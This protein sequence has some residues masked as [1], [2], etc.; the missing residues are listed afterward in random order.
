MRKFYLL[1]Y[2]PPKTRRF[3]LHT[4]IEIKRLCFVSV[5]G[6]HLPEFRSAFFSANADAV[7][8]RTSIEA[9][10][11]T[12]TVKGGN[13]GFV[14]S[15]SIFLASMADAA[16]I[17]KKAGSQ[18]RGTKL[19]DDICV[20]L[21]IELTQAVWTT[22]AFYSSRQCIHRQQCHF[23]PLACSSGAQALSEDAGLE[24]TDSTGVRRNGRAGASRA[25]PPRSAQARQKNEAKTTKLRTAV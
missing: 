20:L 7:D 2:W 1:D 18:W 15:L 4:L 3:N 22:E 12:G 6:A 17:L 5:A 11:C 16:T 8:G 14:C 25:S 13:A 21:G 24:G 23:C 19:V 9:M 10:T